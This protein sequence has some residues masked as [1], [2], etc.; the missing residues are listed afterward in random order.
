MTILAEC[1]ATEGTVQQMD[2]V[3][4][5]TLIT[6][7]GVICQTAVAA[8]LFIF[9]RFLGVLIRRRRYVICWMQA[10]GLLA[11][12]LAVLMLATGPLAASPWLD[13]GLFL[14]LYGKLLFFLLI[15]MGAYAYAQGLPQRRVLYAIHVITL[16]YALAVFAYAD[17]IRVMLQAQVPWA[18]LTAAIG[19]WS[20]WRLPRP[21]RSSG[22][23]L[24]ALAVWLFGGAWTLYLW[25]YQ[26]APPTFLFSDDIW[27]RIA[28]YSPFFDA[29]MQ[30]VL[31][32][33]MLRLLLEDGKRETDSAYAELELAFQRLL[34]E[35]YRDSLTGVLNRRAYQE[36][37]GLEASRRSYG[38]VVVFDLDN[39]KHVNDTRGHAVGDAL[40]RYFAV[41]LQSRLRPLDRLYR[42]GGDEFL[43]V[44]PRATPEDT[45]DRMRVVL[46]EIPPMDYDVE[47]VPIQVSLGCARFEIGA[48]LPEAIRR[49][50]REMYAQKRSRKT[51]GGTPQPRDV[52]S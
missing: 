31:A 50:D 19:G 5:D 6:N 1:V 36:G 17:S 49:A 18:V 23:L 35:A 33:G 39:L 51:L 21:A 43:L 2:L 46:S 14:Y 10:W 27:S 26:V 9:F 8:L 38:T 12:A 28:R 13:A 40:L 24:A 4:V 44:L 7:L 15:A 11:L 37:V 16:L 29:V 47:P 22:S 41:Q 32:F 52:T 48:L 45:R 20:L 25:I 30:L 34:A 3:H 42:W